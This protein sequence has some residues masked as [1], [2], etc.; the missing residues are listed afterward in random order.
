MSTIRRASH[1]G[2]Y[3]K[4]AIDELNITIEEFSS[5]SGISVQD[6]S[7]LIVG[8]KDITFENAKKLSSYFH[9][10]PEGWMNLQASYNAWRESQK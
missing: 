10:S 5:R 2:I 9:N 8:K 3:I 6:V 1:P 7:M 4:D